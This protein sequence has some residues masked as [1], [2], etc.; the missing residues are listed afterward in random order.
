[1]VD[2]PY[3]GRTCPVQVLELAKTLLDLG[4]FEISL[5]DT[6]GVATPTD[7]RALLDCLLK[8]IEPSR[9]AGHF[10]D[11]FGQAVANVLVAYEM[12]IRTFDS[13][14]SGLGGCPYSPGA[15]GNV[16]TEDLVYMFHKMH[17]ETAVDLAMLA[18]TGEWIAQQLQ[19]PNGSRAGAALVARKKPKPQD[20]KAQSESKQ[21]TWQLL[22]EPEALIV[23]RNGATL[24]ITMNR[25]KNGN[26]LTSGM[27]TSL[28]DLFKD[29]AKDRSYFRIIL[30]NSGKYFCTGM[31]LKN[32]T[33]ETRKQN[34]LLLRDLF[35]TIDASPQTT[36]A[37]VNGSAFGG[38]VGL[39]FAC[40]IR[41][42]SEAT[43][44]RLTEVRLGICP[45][46]ISKFVFREWGLAFAREAMLSARPVS[47][48][49]LVQ[50]TGAVH[51]VCPTD[52]E[53]KFQTMV[54]DYIRN[55]RWC[56]PGGMSR[57]K[58]LTSASWKLQGSQEQEA[59]I[60]KTFDEM[61]SSEEQQIGIAA[62]SRGVRD[63]DW[64]KEMQRRRESK[65]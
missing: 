25:P 34:F 1:M 33:V 5:G 26:A 22:Q 54:H 49:E 56:A 41:L 23:H 60:E 37:V 28:I 16:A 61:M 53:A 31:D 44:F 42:A 11:T 36:I 30:T 13:S 29:A 40:D 27:I 12:G 65:L 50:K 39:A 19:Q 43:S 35:N 15:K 38:G 52:E 4:C 32:A 7:V 45:A 63:I 18:D 64:E 20:D 58:Q 3:D 6:T 2:C 10:H 17:V 21:V 9:L 46:V 47:V 8:E 55:L 51:L 62:F 48:L 14:V 57:V 59:V 24:R